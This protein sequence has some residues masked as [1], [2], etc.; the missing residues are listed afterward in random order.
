V[1]AVDGAATRALFFFFFWSHRFYQ[2]L[3]RSHL[4]EE[5]WK[6]FWAQRMPNLYRDLHR[7]RHGMHSDTSK[8]LP[9]DFS[10][11]SFFSVSVLLFLIPGPMYYYFLEI[12]GHR[13]RYEEQQYRDRKDTGSVFSL[14]SLFSVSVLLFLIRRPMSYYFLEI[15]EHR[16]RFEE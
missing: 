16:Y 10:L 7:S 4:S 15:L 9:L 3:R 6:N 5:R 2:V 13:Y 1:Q 14:S 8:Q 11:F 12:L